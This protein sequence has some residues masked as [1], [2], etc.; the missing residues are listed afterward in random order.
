MNQTNNTENIDRELLEIQ[1]LIKN[2]QN[3]EVEQKLENLYSKFPNDIVLSTIYAEYSFNK[4]NLKKSKEILELLTKNYP[5][6]LFGNKLYGKILF[7]ESA[8]DTAIY[9]LEKALQA[10]NKQNPQ[11]KE[12]M[13]ELLYY[14]GVS[15]YKLEYFHQADYYLSLAQRIDHTY[16]DLFYIVSELKPLLQIFESYKQH[17]SDPWFLL[18]AYKTFRKSGHKLHQI[19]FFEELKEKGARILDYD[20]IKLDLEI[21]ELL[22]R[23]AS[24][25]EVENLNQ[26]W[27]KRNKFAGC[28]FTFHELFF[29]KKNFQRSISR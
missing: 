13:L 17:S 6:Y 22:D 18:A 19:K 9:F 20:L 10:A 8:Y 25:Q 26:E 11:I 28:V 23:N 4:A 29:D 3:E 5:D 16:K 15:R 1:N 24:Y 2:N 21:C 12:E 7:E 14:C 27:Q